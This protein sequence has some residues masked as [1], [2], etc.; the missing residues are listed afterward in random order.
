[1]NKPIKHGSPSFLVD[2]IGGLC[3]SESRVLEFGC[4]DG[5]NLIKLRKKNFRNLVGVDKD[6]KKIETAKSKLKDVSLY[7]DD[8]LNFKSDQKFEIIFHTLMGIF[9]SV[10]QRKELLKIINR[11]LKPGGYYMF[12]EICRDSGKRDSAP[13]FYTEE[14]IEKLKDMFKTLSVKNVERIVKGNVVGGGVIYI[15]KKES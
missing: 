7:C 13:Y 2:E 5:R 14:E 15:G 11:Y 3:S 10:E 8:V 4:G 9:L 1:M 12:E 6:P